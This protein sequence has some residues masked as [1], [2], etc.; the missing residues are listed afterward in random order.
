MLVANILGLPAAYFIARKW[1][2]GFAYRIKLGP[3]F[4]LAAVGLSFAIACLTVSSQA[5]KAAL[6][7]PV[8]SLRYE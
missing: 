1:L 7:D 6:A 8:N 3:E 4:F 5:V 2:A